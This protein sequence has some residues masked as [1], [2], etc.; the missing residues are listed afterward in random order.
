M[1]F[2]ARVPTGFQRAWNRSG[3][4][5][6]T[7][8]QHTVKARSK[9]KVASRKVNHEVRANVSK[10]SSNPSPLSIYPSL[11]TSTLLESTMHAARLD[12]ST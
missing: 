10:K 11:L 12:S 3:D 7:Q 9:S 8:P 4:T 5:R 1:G 2:I 6:H